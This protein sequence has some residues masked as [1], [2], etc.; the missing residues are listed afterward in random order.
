MPAVGGGLPLD[1]GVIAGGYRVEVFLHGGK[2]GVGDA[3]NGGHVDACISF[4]IN[5]LLYYW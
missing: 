5:I 3:A 4:I 1:V 2:I